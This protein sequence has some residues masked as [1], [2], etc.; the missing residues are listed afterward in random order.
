MR[1]GGSLAGE[2]DR[3]ALETHVDVQPL[4]CLC[5]LGWR[6]PGGGTEI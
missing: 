5:I 2:R 6:D 3:G 4:G 1:E